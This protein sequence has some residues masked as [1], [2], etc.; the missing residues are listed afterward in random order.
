M[1]QRRNYDP[2]KKVVIIMNEM[3]LLIIYYYM[4]GG[5]PCIIK[6]NIKLNIT[7][8]IYVYTNLLEMD[9]MYIICIL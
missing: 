2:S 9:C 1:S 5:G 4:V 3:K 7:Y 8:K 6:K